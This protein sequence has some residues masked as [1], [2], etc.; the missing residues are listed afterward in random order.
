MK[1][2]GIVSSPR[3]GGN[4]QTFVE[5]ILSGAREEGAETEVIRLCDMDI[6]PC[7]GCNICKGGDGCFIEDDM[8][9]LVDI[10]AETDVLVFGSPLYWGRLN[11]QAYPFIDRLYALLKPDFSTDFP[12]G[13]KLVVALTCGGM[14]PDEMN[15]VNEYIKNIFGFLGFV[16]G[17]FIWQN[18]CLMPDDLAKFPDRIKEAEE[19]GR[20]LVKDSH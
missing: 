15:P 2:T 14:G 19:L 13:K 4:S 12:Q 11:A 3:K 5:H 7:T 20:N 6:Q 8:N 18:Q 10:L 17:G 16:D 1:I 9:Y